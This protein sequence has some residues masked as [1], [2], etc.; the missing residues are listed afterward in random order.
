MW[1]M[2]YVVLS[3]V[4]LFEGVFV[5]RGLVYAMGWGWVVL[6]VVVG[7]VLS[8][9]GVGSVL[10]ITRPQFLQTISPLVLSSMMFVLWHSEHC[11]TSRILCLLLLWLIGC[12]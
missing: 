7:G 11:S 9:G 5:P 10:F 2:V 1:W 6:V 4:L 12:C 3:S 8:C